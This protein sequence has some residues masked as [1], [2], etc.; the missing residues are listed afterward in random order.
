M[1][2][3]VAPPRGVSQLTVGDLTVTWDQYRALPKAERRALHEAL[4]T[5]L[6]Q[7]YRDWDAAAKAIRDRHLAEFD[8][9]KARV[10]AK[11]RR[12]RE[13]AVSGL[14][15]RCDAAI[16]KE[17]DATLAPIVSTYRFPYQFEEI[18]FAW[19][20]RVETP[21]EELQRRL[22]HHDWHYEY[23][24]DSRVYQAGREARGRIQ[25]LVRQ[26]GP[27]GEREYNRACPW[28]NEDGTRKVA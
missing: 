10:T 13:R 3:P 2:E 11:T 27:E 15:S 18:L 26:L 1:T 24:D 7:A 16:Q 4:C 22:A 21:M 6:S 9:A 5:K 17:A 28:L 8:A 19:E 20:A 23:S 12:E 25:S 14:L